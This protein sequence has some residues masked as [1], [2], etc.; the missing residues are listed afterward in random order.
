MFNT[1]IKSS[2]DELILTFVKY[3]FIYN[4]DNNGR[5]RSAFSSKKT[6][7]KPSSTFVIVTCNK[8]IYKQ[9]SLQ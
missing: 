9:Y 2:F 7:K 3:N 4:E 1:H 8:N 5:M 6:E